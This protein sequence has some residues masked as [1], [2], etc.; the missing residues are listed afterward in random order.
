MDISE[1]ILGIRRSWKG[2]QDKKREYYR[3]I[4]VT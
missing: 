3:N 4:I 2:Y 1:Y